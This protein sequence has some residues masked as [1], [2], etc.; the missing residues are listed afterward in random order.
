M[1]ASTEK[2]RKE[3]L[4]AALAC[5]REHG[6][7]STS[8]E[9]IRNKSG[10]S[11]GSIYHH[12]HSKEELAQALYVEGLGEYQQALLTELARHRSAEG[13]VRAVVEHYLTWV[14]EHIDLTQYLVLMRQADFVAQSDVR[15]SRAT[16]FKGAAELFQPHFEAGE[17][18]PMAFPVFVAV[19]T[20]PVQEYTRHWLGHPD[21][22]D[23]KRARK[24]LSD[25][26]WLSVRKESNS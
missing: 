17:L 18:R 1:R 2:R 15:T 20:G 5:F 6:F 16:F 26:A 23:M 10:A 21:P 14:S 9:Q 11:V 24:I 19:L 7:G 4:D 25:A 22:A 8:M 13:K 3:I 12:F